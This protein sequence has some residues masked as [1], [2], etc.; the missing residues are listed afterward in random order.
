MAN[1]QIPEFAW[2]YDPP[3]AGNFAGLSIS[4]SPVIKPLR[5]RVAPIRL[6]ANRCYH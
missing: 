4:R 1:R 5:W 3:A 2:I 6:P